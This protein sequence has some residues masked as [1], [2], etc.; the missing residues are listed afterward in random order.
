MGPIGCP[1]TSVTTNLR[2][3][4]CKKNEDPT[5]SFDCVKI[6][7]RLI[8]TYSKLPKPQ[9]S[10]GKPGSHAWHIW[11]KI[12]TCG[13]LPRHRNGALVQILAICAS[14]PTVG[15]IGTSQRNHRCWFTNQVETFVAFPRLVYTWQADKSCVWTYHWVRR[16][17]YAI[18]GNTIMMIWQIFGECTRVRMFDK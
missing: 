1:E 12:V 9:K 6:A 2:C 13:Y 14:P 7:G 3:V 5:N 11:Q 17:K 18:R 16:V 15:K 8:F 4:T 10:T